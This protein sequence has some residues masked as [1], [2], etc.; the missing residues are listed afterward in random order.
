MALKRKA[1]NNLGGTRKSTRASN[2]AIVISGR[3]HGDT[4]LNKKCAIL[5]LPN[6]CLLK[7][8]SF[9]SLN[10]LLAVG[11]SC[12]RFG[13]LADRVAKENLRVEI[14]EYFDPNGEDAAILERFGRFMQNVVSHDKYSLAWLQQCTSLKT[15]K[16]CKTQLD[17]SWKCART[18]KK[19][20]SL[21]LELCFRD[22]YGHGVILQTCKKLKS[23]SIILAHGV[24][25][26]IFD[27]R[28]L[29][30]YI[31]GML[32]IERISFSATNT[33][34]A[35]AYTVDMAIRML[36][37]K[38]LK[39]L[40]LD[41]CNLNYAKFIDTLSGSES[42]EE[43]HLTVIYLYDDV[44]RALDAFSNLKSCE[45]THEPGSRY[46]S[47]QF[48]VYNLARLGEK[49]TNFNAMNYIKSEHSRG[50][51]SVTLKRKN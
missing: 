28:D 45:I 21:T 30:Q 38:R 41:I 22:M 51:F 20:E 31:T 15:L 4:Q 17:F 48:P 3:H 42:L 27:C 16:L 36:R 25:A 10:H 6:E 14:F 8:F 1:S 35:D 12:R 47:A 7:F 23:I 44:L 11:D 46:V 29:L 19:L 9:I 2:D 39:F 33:Q 24:R 26:S 50:G 18:L 43:L 49:L 13:A 5:N 37:L 32:N 34:Q 40:S